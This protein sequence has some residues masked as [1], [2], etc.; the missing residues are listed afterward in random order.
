M[1]NFIYGILLTIGTSMIFGAKIHQI[2]V[3]SQMLE[4]Q[5]FVEYFWFYLAGFVG[6][7]TPVFLST[8]CK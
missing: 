8:R 2:V 1:R 3:N 7:S 5:A 6:V 4:A